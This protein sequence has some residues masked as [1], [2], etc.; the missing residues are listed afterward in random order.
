MPQDQDVAVEG[1]ERD[2]G[3]HGVAGQA[4]LAVR[5]DEGDLG[6]QGIDLIRRKGLRRRGIRPSKAV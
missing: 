3:D 4:P 2:Q 1:S 6:D 5:M